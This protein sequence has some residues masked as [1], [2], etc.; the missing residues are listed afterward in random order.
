[1]TKEGRVILAF[2]IGTIVLVGGLAF[3]MT[4]VSSGDGSGRDKL[5]PNTPIEK[6]E[7]NPPGVMDLGD[8]PYRGGVISKSFEVKNTSDSEI[9]LKK[10]TTSC[11]CTKAKFVVD[12]RESKFYGMEMN[13]DLNPL[14]DYKLAPGKTARV[15]FDF[16]PAAHGP[17][18]I[19]PVDRTITLFFDTGFKELSFH[20]VVANN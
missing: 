16:D 3:W 5:V 13:G 6:L 11:M 1:M 7:A 8:V 4:K 20:G 15:I 18:G 19:G 12:G 9:S 17:Q 14:I 2:I 10:I